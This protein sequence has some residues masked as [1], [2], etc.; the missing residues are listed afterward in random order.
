MKSDDKTFSCIVHEYSQPL[1]WHI[2]RMVVDHDDAQ[3]VLQNTFV[4]AFRFLWTLRDEG[5]LKPWLYRIATNEANR[6]L[7]RKTDRN[8]LTD[9]LIQTL[10]SSSYV[11]YT[12]EAEIKLQK[13]L[14]GLSPQQRTVFCLRYYDEMEYDEI[15]KVTGSKVETLKVAYHYAREKVK[16]YLEEN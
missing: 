15:S 2:R 12:R 16:K 13:A 3:D 6:F 4:K 7:S 1:Y 11:D 8:A 10:E 5:A 9:T 14:L